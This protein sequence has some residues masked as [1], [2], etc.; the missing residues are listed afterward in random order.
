[1]GGDHVQGGEFEMRIENILKLITLDFSNLG[2]FVLAGYAGS[3]TQE[4][5][6]KI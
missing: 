1:M 6:L 2:L 3:K 4:H 5:Y